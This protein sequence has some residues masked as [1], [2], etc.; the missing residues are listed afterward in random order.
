MVAFSLVQRKACVIVPFSTSTATTVITYFYLKEFL[1][2]T[3]EVLKTFV[4]DVLT[5]FFDQHFRERCS[6]DQGFSFDKMG[7][8]SGKS[9]LEFWN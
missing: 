7:R 2:Y 3:G 4:C 1:T 6:F 5:F 9:R 8:Y